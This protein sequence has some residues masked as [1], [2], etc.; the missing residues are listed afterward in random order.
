MDSGTTLGRYK[1][2]EK[3]GSG[4][5]GQVYLAQDTTLG[6][7]VALKLLSPEVA[8]DPE[9]RAR[10][11][12]EARAVAAL[13]HPNIVTIHAIEREGDTYFIAM[14][15]VA[16]RTLSGETFADGLPLVQFFDIARPLVDAVKCAHE[17]GVIHRDL[18][19]D[20]VMVDGSGRL[21]V[22]DFGLAK[23]KP[24]FLEENIDTRAATA[25]D[26]SVAG[27]ILGTIAYM[28]PE[29]AEG[30]EV[31]H[32]SDIFSLGIMLHELI[33]GRRP[34]SGDS[35]ASMISSLLRDQAPTIT[36]VNP[37]L[38]EDLSAVITRCLA[39][40]PAARYQSAQE[41]A[42]DLGAVHGRLT[43][44]LD[45]S[46]H[47]RASRPATS[48][49]LPLAL[50]AALVAVTIALGWM[51]MTRGARRDAAPIVNASFTQLTHEPGQELYPTLSA[52]GRTIV[53]ARAGAGNMDLFALRVGGE[54]ATNLTATSPADDSQPAFSPDSER[55]V[56]RSERD[57]GGLFVMGATGES[58]RRLTDFGFHPAWSPDGQHV[59]C[60]TQNVIDPGFRFTTSQLWVVAVATG[61]KRLLGEA[62][63][64]QPSWSPNGHRI[65]YWGR[66]GENARGDIWTV[67]VGGG[68]AVASTTDP[69][70]DWNPVWSPDGTALYFLSDRGGSMNVWRMAVDERSG[71]V[72]GAPEPVTTGA[73]TSTQHLT[74]AKD[75][76]LAYVVRAETM[77]IQRVGFDP[78]AAA[79]TGLPSPVTRGSRTFAQ[80]HLSSDQSQ[81]A[82]NTSGK[83]EDIFVS[84]ADGTA[85]QQVTD[86]GFI[87]R[88]AR[89]SPDG[90]RIA[91]YSDR[92]GKFEIWAIN[93]DGSGLRQLS[94]SPGAH[95]PVWSPDGAR[96]AFS[97]HA[98][99]GAAIFDTTGAWNSQTLVRLPDIPDKTQSFE[100]WSWS[101]DGRW[102]AGQRHLADLSHAGIGIHE[103]GSDTLDW[104]TDFGEWPVWL[105]DGRRMLFSHQGKLHLL[106]RVTKKTTELL[107]LPQNNLGSVGLAADDRAIYFTVMAAEADLWMM[108]VK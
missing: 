83:K 13:N 17:K 38:P 64:A 47:G 92:T 21:K 29:Q 53:Y 22:L 62:D 25:H 34:F 19:P 85:L 59:A 43:S 88:A 1:I 27:Q 71:A 67:A 48:K 87:D 90:R 28:S 50:T 20:N 91:F 77:N 26:R 10:F 99:N 31:D 35:S 56:F 39:K 66:A 18:K 42:R 69:A 32:R 58:V 57:G 60:V 82:F 81:L 72:L 79:I 54:N 61:E 30:K 89:W 7:N 36:A 6:R 68:P 76:R 16:G 5:M 65:A 103:I 12:R 49:V 63:A 40:D 2:V 52:D 94:Q 14:E 104:L 105:R 106:D 95:Y 73:G 4:G 98:P 70:T 41:L 11:E 86:D 100:V 23:L 102:L 96:M 37:A 9:R 101:G 93:R 24:G 78:D 84:R 74:I 51:W 3:I 8:D 46:L 108:T 15:Y 97:T 107:A 33:T 75:G 44:S 55:L 45:G 80:P